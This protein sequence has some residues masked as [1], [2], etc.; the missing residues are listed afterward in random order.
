MRLIVEFLGLARRLAQTKD[1]MLQTDKAATCADVLRR[2]AED[3]PALIGPVIDS[4][5]HELVPSYMLNLNGRHAVRDLSASPQDGDRLI[6]M[7]VEAGG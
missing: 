4:E 1:C 6:L 3:Y 7:F 5:T 2:L